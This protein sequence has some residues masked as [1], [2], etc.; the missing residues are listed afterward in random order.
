MPS[1]EMPCYVMFMAFNDKILHHLTF[2]D[3]VF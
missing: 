2:H 3:M 1:Y